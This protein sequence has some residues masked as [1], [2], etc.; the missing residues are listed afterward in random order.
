M[1]CAMK[2]LEK[3]KLINLNL[4]NNLITELKVMSL[5]GNKCQNVSK[6]YG[7][8]TD[9]KYFYMIMEYATDG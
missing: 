4:I 6:L 1:I 2:I 9:R 5:L 3:Q 8:F 7:F